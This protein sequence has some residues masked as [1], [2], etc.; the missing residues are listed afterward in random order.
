MIFLLILAIVAQTLLLVGIALKLNLFNF[1][2]GK[3]GIVLDTSSVIDGRVLAIV[4]AGFLNGKKLISTD[5]I[6][7][8][9]QFL[10]DGG[11]SFKRS[12]AR[13]G[14][15]ILNKLSKLCGRDFITIPLKGVGNSE[16][17]VDQKLLNLAK[18]TGGQLLTTDFNL[19]SRARV[20]GVDVINPVELATALKPMVLPGEV[21]KLKLIQKGEDKNQA[22]GYLDDGTM[23]VAEGL[24]SKIGQNIELKSSKIIQTPGGRIIFAAEN[25]PTRRVS[26]ASTPKP[27]ASPAPKL[28][29]K[30]LEKPVVKSVPDPEQTKVEPPKPVAVEKPVRQETQTGRKSRQKPDNRRQNTKRLSPEDRLFKAL[31]RDD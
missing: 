23:V 3:G 19:A 31:G 20:E 22:V 8:E 24:Q 2:G 4:E 28:K 5:L 14:L 10:A 7:D 21:F 26:R 6:L 16:D 25:K 30:A 1:K 13:Y 29:S 9:L 17:G 18:K 12:R 11:D 27:N 15:D